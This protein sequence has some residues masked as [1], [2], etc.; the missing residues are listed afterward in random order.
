VTG[1]RSCLVVAALFAMA[2]LSPAAAEATFP[3]QNG[4]I[5][6]VTSRDGGDYD[7]YAMSA[8][9]SA[10]TPLTSNTE[11]DITPAWSP[12]GTKI[13]FATD[14]DAGNYEIY[15][16]NADGSGQTRLT[17]S[18]PAEGDPAWSPDGTKIAFARS[19]DIHVMNADGT[20]QT[21]LIT[22]PTGSYS[23]PDWSPDGSRIAFIRFLAGDLPLTQIYVANADGS[24]QT[25]LTPWNPDDPDFRGENRDPT[26]SPNGYR[27]AFAHDTC[28]GGCDDKPA[29]A[30]YFVS[31]SAPGSY[32]YSSGGG[33]EPAWSPD[34]TLIAFDWCHF[35]PF[36]ECDGVDVGTLSLTGGPQ[37]TLTDDRRSVSPAWQ[38]I[39]INSYP[40]PKGATPMYASL[41]P[42][43]VAC[44][45]PNR[46]H[47]P[48]LAFD[49]CGST[50]TPQ[51]LPANSPH[52]SIGSPDHNG[53]TANSVGFTR[54]D[55]KVGDPATPADEADVY[56]ALRATDVRCIHTSPVPTC[57]ALN[58]A[59]GPDY[60]GELEGQLDLRLTDKDNTPH[61]GG[62]GAGTV[63]DFGLSL[64][65]PCVE[66]SENFIGGTCAIT[67]SA[68]GLVPGMVKEGKRAI[69]QL[70]P[71]RVLDGGADGDAD[72]AADNTLFMKQ[73]IFVP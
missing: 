63:Q 31:P 54:L 59:D 32:T 51:S 61:P 29:F 36:G 37:M 55:V 73:G 34:G 60:T 17:N 8:D 47:G 28:E 6:F 48:P 26:W 10:E 22:S 19:G 70:G 40:R 11:H 65:V 42:A 12:D 56:L 68:D 15:V 44:T 67:T 46:T 39:P 58:T 25:S 14:R 3:G 53:A 52:I 23:S 1:R 64:A 21:P 72:T 38:P 69:W 50:T 16:M 49:S 18:A 7:I 57:G 4:K 43:F 41:V 35:T 33:R 5:A 27:I 2:L 9:G 66:T 71:V 24:G 62:P 45:A 20:N 30:V 13:A